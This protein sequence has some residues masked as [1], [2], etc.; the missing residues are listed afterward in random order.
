[1]SM[2]T[3]RWIGPWYPCSDGT[4]SVVQNAMPIGGADGFAFGSAAYALKCSGWPPSG[5]NAA[6]AGNSRFSSADGS[7]SV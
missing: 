2:P 5:E 4:R 7:A 3:S 6:A 1:M